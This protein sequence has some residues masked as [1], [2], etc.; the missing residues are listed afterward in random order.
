MSGIY[1]DGGWIGVDFD[2]TLAHRAH[3]Q[4]LKELGRPV[5]PMVRRVKAWLDKG[6]D[7]RIFTAR[8]APGPSPV[9]D[10]TEGIEAWCLEHLG[11][12]LPITCTK[13]F[14]MIQLWDDRAVGVVPNTGRIIGCDTC[15]GSGEIDQREGGVA[16]SGLAQCPECCA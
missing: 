4:P 10:A 5:M 3:D 13:D 12:V 7:V 8:A 9:S 14:A 11:K 6:Y 2:G 16:T 1:W 15:G